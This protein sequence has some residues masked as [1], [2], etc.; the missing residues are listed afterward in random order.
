MDQNRLKELTVFRSQPLSMGLPRDVMY[1]LLFLVAGESLVIAWWVGVLLF[2]VIY[3]AL[4]VAHER[5]PAA[6]AV[7]RDALA[8]RSPV[9]DPAQIKTIPYVFR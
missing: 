9:I 5:D 7:W 4:Y 3:P 8:A 2:A 1:P 6:A